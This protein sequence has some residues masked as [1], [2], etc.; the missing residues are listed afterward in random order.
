MDIFVKRRLD[1]NNWFYRL[2]AYVLVDG[3]FGSTGKGLLAGLLA[4]Y[5]QNAITSV[6]TNAGPNSGHTAYSPVDGS[7]IVTQQIP[8]A[9]VVL[10][11]LGKKASAYLNA[12]AVI[13]WEILHREIELF[14]MVGRVEIHPNAA[15]I[16]QIDRDREAG[17]PM[18]QA[19]S[20]AA[21]ASTGKGVG[22]ALARKIMRE[23]NVIGT[24]YGA[25]EMANGDSI[26]WDWNNETVFVETA[27][28][29]SLGINSQFYPH[30]T[31]RECT[32]MQA[33]ADARIPWNKV[34]KVAACYR[35]FPIRVGNTE[36][37]YSG[38]W[39]PDQQ[40]TTWE[41]I[42]V[43]PELTTV[44]R[45]VRRVA[46][47][48]RQQFRESIAANQPELVFLNFLNY[49]KRELWAGFIEQLLLDYRNAMGHDLPILLVG[50]G[51]KSTDV[52]VW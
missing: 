13:D 31:S 46:T 8:V 14:G 26:A 6:T 18:V 42:G 27:Q 9:A 32:V 22:S 30:T 7:K 25:F 41:A 33:I 50:T 23:G 10:N 20:V 19:G 52:A 16:Q 39:Y 40:E 17:G 4:E 44:T 49:L 11:Q 2:G 36:V 28:G 37:G 51:P 3:Q 15:V 48:S 1:N 47:W 45:R 34:K 5:G 38:D 29:F 12:G 24:G 35:T 21:I 43:E